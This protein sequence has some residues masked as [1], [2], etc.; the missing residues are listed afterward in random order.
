MISL[1]DKI[2]KELNP[3]TSTDNCCMLFNASSTTQRHISK[4]SSN[5]N[6]EEEP[7]LSISTDEQ[8]YD[9][10]DQQLDDY[11]RSIEIL[12]NDNKNEDENRNKNFNRIPSRKL[13]N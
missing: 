6:N 9:G 7:F 1:L 4:N 5:T 13:F 8:S 12:H 10:S 3:S 11:K 2:D